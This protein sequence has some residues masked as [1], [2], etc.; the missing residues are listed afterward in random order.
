V[1]IAIDFVWDSATPV[2]VYI[3]LNRISLDQVRNLRMKYLRG[4]SLMVGY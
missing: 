3:G 2:S 1:V 4:L